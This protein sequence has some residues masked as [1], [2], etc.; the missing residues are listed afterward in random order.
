MSG[1]QRVLGWTGT[2]QLF[3]LFG[4]LVA[5]GHHRRVP[6]FTLYTGGIAV[7]STAMGLWYTLDTWMVHHVA[8]AALRF[9]VAIELTYAIFGAFPA[10]A[11]TARRVM[12]VLLI[13]TAAI[14]ARATT[15]AEFIGKVVPQMATGAVWMLTALAALVLWYRVPLGALQ[16]A[17]LMGLATYLLVFTG[18]MNVL[19]TAAPAARPW[20][21]YANSLSFFAL[22]MYWCWTAW[23][24]APETVPPA[25]A[26]V[27][28]RSLP[29]DS[30][31]SA[32]Q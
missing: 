7:T 28:V 17:I 2:A 3:I 29:I 11:V 32:S 10:A 15:Y 22:V 12:F 19:G 13:S 14:S 24:L 21:G 8:T 30:R 4:L 18:A 1:L 26:R 23:K 16:K 27:P 31:A 6:F 20:I 25:A 9:G 5:R